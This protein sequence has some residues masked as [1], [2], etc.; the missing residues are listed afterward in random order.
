MPVNIFIFKFFKNLF[1]FFKGDSLTP[2]ANTEQSRG[3]TFF[4]RMRTN[5]E[6]TPYITMVV[7]VALHRDSSGSDKTFL[8]CIARR[9]PINELKD[10]PSL[11]GFDQFSSR[12]NLQYDIENLD[13]SHMK[14]ETIDMNF[15]GKNFRDYVYSN[16]IPLINRHFQ[17]VI[18]KGESK[19]SIYRFCLHD[20]IYAFVN[21]QSKLFSNTTTGKSESIVST[22]TIVRLIDNINDLNGTASTR[23]MKSIITSNRDL[24]KNKQSSVS[25]KMVTPPPPTTP[26]IGTQFALTML[27]MHK[28]ASNSL[29]QHVSSTL[30]TLFQVQNSLSSPNDKTQQQQ[31]SE[32]SPPKTN[33]QKSSTL[34]SKNFFSFCFFTKYFLL[35]MFLHR[36]Q[37]N[38]AVNEHPLV[39]N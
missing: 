28:N 2:T 19:S 30:G 37:L 18:E 25:N 5:D 38:S 4:C 11:L 17:E 26:P 9:P 20:D 36:I 7:S 14:S 34:D 27:G 35:K 1:L 16:D 39:H 32:P 23:L 3:R 33:A 12:I 10:K 22:H 24:Q 21:T 31:S 13:S 6:S 15:L 29:Q 8:I